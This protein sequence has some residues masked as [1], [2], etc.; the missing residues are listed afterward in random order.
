M[1]NPENKN[2]P[3]RLFR[4]WAS[5]LSF[6]P[7]CLMLASVYLLINNPSMLDIKSLLIFNLIGFGFIFSLLIWRGVLLIQNT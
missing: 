4:I 6:I 5:W 1:K 7:L 3:L 2:E